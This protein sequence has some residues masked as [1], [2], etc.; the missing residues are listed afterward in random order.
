MRHQD[1]NPATQSLEQCLAVRK[2]CLYERNEEL[3]AAADR[4][5]QCYAMAG[6]YQDAKDCLRRCLD[7]VKFRYERNP[8]AKL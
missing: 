5:A 3:V 8:D 2:S 1:L 7:A 4:L 6:R